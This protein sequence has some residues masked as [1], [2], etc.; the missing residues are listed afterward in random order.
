MD[1]C[2]TGALDNP[3]FN[4]ALFPTD[5]VTSA[6]TLRA[7]ANRPARSI[8]PL[9]PRQICTKVGW[10]FSCATMPPLGLPLQAVGGCAELS[11][12]W[13]PKPQ[14]SAYQ[15][16]RGHP[17]T[18]QL[19]AVSALSIVDTQHQYPCGSFPLTPSAPRSTGEPQIL[20]QDHVY[21]S[22]I[23]HRFCTV[24]I[25]RKQTLSNQTKRGTRTLY[26]L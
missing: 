22:Q 6:R 3:Q 17:Q 13:S 7:A 10:T 12:G 9:L 11:K 24:E 2:V 4:H 20:Q 26:V 8:L 5:A 21:P 18:H 14:R 25:Q 15:T 19:S 23:P 16:S 1:G